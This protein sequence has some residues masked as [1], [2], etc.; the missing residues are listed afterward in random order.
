MDKKTL[1]IVI[2][3]C[4]L[5]VGLMGRP[6]EA[7]TLS[8]A[9]SGG[10]FFAERSFTVA[11][12]VASPD[13]ALNAVQGVLSFPAKQLQVLSVSTAG[14][15]MNFW[16]QDP[17]FSNQ[18]GTVNFAGIVVNPGYEGPSA[19]VFTITFAAAAPGPAA[20]SFTSGSVLANDGKGTA[21]LSGTTGA[22]FTILPLAAGGAGGS[23]PPA[24][25]ITTIPAIASDQWYNI[26]KVTLDW[27]IPAGA[28]GVDYEISDNPTYQ[29]AHVNR[30]MV[31]SVTYDL[32]NFV[33]GKWYF[34]LSF[35]SGDAW[36]TPAVKKIMIDRAPPDPFTIT[37]VDADPRN[38]RPVFT[39]AANDPVSGI[40]RY[41]AKIGNGDWFDPS[42]LETVTSTYVLP[43][44]SPTSDRT[45]TVRAFDGAGNYRDA[46]VAF[47]VLSLLPQEASIACPS[48]SP[49][50]SCGLWVFFS[51]WEWFVGILAIA[52]LVFAYALIYNLLRWRKI[53]QREL[54]EFRG[55]LESN[56]AKIREGDGMGGAS[57][58]KT[59]EHIVQD[60]N[61]EIERF[62]QNP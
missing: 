40:S 14:S 22:T 37:R 23:S 53:M 7:A 55:E 12:Q 5:A 39:W 32:S 24:V 47:D 4:A 10:T 56:L 34:F 3:A 27:S 58:E 18:D 26:N 51:Q 52:L 15:I 1:S 35:A 60:V 30:G 62:D 41:E 45:L 49:W 31:S 44:Q 28:D 36:S 57:S 29:L 20:V 46:S 17:I 21:I 9:P 61:K 6:A 13:Q 11:V 48:P 16:V 42:I 43:P 8:L 54:Q 25:D 59:I 2:V 50:L 19:T 38:P 33:D